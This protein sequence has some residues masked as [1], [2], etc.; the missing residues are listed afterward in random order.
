VG[1][2]AKV[3]SRAWPWA[4]HE[5]LEYLASICKMGM[6]GHSSKGD[7]AMELLT[8]SG[9]HRDCSVKGTMQMQQGCHAAS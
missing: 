9:K 5:A 4:S 1:L 2:E 6:T 7:Q 8:P 3:W